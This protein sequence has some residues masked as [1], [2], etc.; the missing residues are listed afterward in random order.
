M[1]NPLIGE[2][3]FLFYS[4]VMGILITF[5]YD[6]LRILRRV[7]PH[8]S[9]FVSLEDLVFWVFCAVSV[10][11]MMLRLS[12]GTLRWFAVLG[13]LAGMF[14]YRKTVSG[15]LVKTVSG[16][17]RGLLR[18]VGKLLGFLGR[19][20]Q[21]AGRKGKETVQCGARKGKLF[22]R[23]LKKRLTRLPKMLR[24]VRKK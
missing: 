4:I 15:F 5:V 2:N 11:L 3:Q 9:F 20:F 10:F 21:F 16:L 14:V 13:A 18:I 7:I 6:L 8:N 22:F 12:D 19:P 1:S 23:Y 24:I 17:L